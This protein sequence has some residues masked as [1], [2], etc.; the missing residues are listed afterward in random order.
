MRVEAFRRLTDHD[1]APTSGPSR[2][3]FSDDVGVAAK[4]TLPQTVADDR[5]LRRVPLNDDFVGL[6]PP[7]ENWLDTEN[8]EGM[9]IDLLQS[10]S[11]GS[12]GH[13]ERRVDLVV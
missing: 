4:Q 9:K 8:F 2:Q 1:F 13:G 5:G 7:A 10:D 11:F 12:G 6:K 3:P